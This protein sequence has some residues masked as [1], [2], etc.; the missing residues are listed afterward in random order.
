MNISHL[1]SIIAK[2]PDEITSEQFGEIELEMEDLLA[3]QRQADEA[4]LA[5]AEARVA[6][7]RVKLNLERSQAIAAESVATAPARSRTELDETDAGMGVR[8]PREES[9]SAQ[10][11]TDELA[12]LR[13]RTQQKRRR[14]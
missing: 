8:E 10:S 5:A 14:L 9:M 7:L 6:A 13:E 11:F 3:Q 4:E 12:A 2:L 1:K